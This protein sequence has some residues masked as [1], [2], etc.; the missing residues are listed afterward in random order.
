MDHMMICNRAWRDI[1]R[2]GFGFLNTLSDIF[3]GLETHHPEA[4]PNL[5]AAE[6]LFVGS[7]YGGEHVGALYQTIAF[8]MADVVECAQWQ[9]I[10]EKIRID[11]HLARR[12]MAF[13]SMNDSVRGK[14]FRGFV[15]SANMIY[16]MLIV[17]AIHKRSGSLFGSGGRFDLTTLDFEPLRTFSAPVAEKL[18]RVVSLLGLLI[19]GFSAPGQDVLWATDEDVIAANAPKARHLV[20]AVALVTSKLLDHDLGRLRVAT[21]KQD[22]GDLS[23]EDLLAIP[24]F[25]AGGLSD[26]LTSMFAHGA[27]PAG[28]EFPRSNAGSAKGRSVLDWFSDNAQPL[29]RM[30]VIIDQELDTK[31]LRATHVRFHGTR[32]ISQ[33]P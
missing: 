20:D 16:G 11:W 19:G 2:N 17:F 12:R 1:S 10:R 6:C 3:V 8:L 23:L 18:M 7:D 29:R 14:A 22:K 4:L 9:S 28:F 33:G 25:A 32:D 30:C 31:K 24:D 13:K 21:A 26:V 27:P 5:R 15:E